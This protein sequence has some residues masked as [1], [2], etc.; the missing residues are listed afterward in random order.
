MGRPNALSPD[1]VVAD[2]SNVNLKGFYPDKALS[3]NANGDATVRCKV[4]SG[5][6]LSG[7]AVSAELPSGQSFGDAAMKIVAHLALKPGTNVH[8]SPDGVVLLPFSF[9][10][11]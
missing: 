7:C 11:K 10:V 5:G 1:L 6:T 9:K 2:K 4:D 3:M 8:P